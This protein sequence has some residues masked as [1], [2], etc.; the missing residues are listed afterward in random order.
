MSYMTETQKNQHEITRRHF[1]HFSA[2]SFVASVVAPQ[3]AI[4]SSPLALKQGKEPLPSTQIN[5]ETGASFSLS[6]VAD[7]PLIINFWATW[8]P[9]CVHELPQLNS[10]ASRLRPDGILVVLVSMDRG[11]PKDAAPFLSAR[12]IDA[13]LQLYDPSADWARA[14]KIKGLPTTLLIPKDKGSYKFHTGPAE[15]ED[16]RI[17]GQIRTYLAP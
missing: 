9:P 10:L 4:A 2:A 16:E 1:I 6:D 17:K 8:C 12:G 11:G 15:W 13:P 14:L 3:G 7:S 5:T